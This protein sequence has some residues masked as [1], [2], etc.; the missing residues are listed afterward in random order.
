L[1]SWKGAVALL[2][3]LI[4]LGTV[5]YLTRPGPAPERF[6]KILPCSLADTVLVRVEAGGKTVEAQRP[7]PGDAWRV[8]QPVSAPADPIV[9]EFFVQ[10]LHS[11]SALNTV[12][13]PDAPATYGLDPPS[14]L[15]TCRVQSGDSYTLAVGKASFDGSGYYAKRGGDGRVFVISSVP[16]DEFDRELAEPPLRSP[17]APASSSPR[18]S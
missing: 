6:G 4:V 15:V 13:N 17:V 3:A 18:P 9:M 14:R 8:T 10:S 16:V 5:V 7:R 2:G 12:P 1:V 11:V